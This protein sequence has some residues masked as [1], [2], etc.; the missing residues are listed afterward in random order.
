MFPWV[1]E[2]RAGLE[3]SICQ[4]IATEREWLPRHDISSPPPPPPHFYFDLG[5]RSTNE[6]SHRCIH[7]GDRYRVPSY[8]L[9]SDDS[10]GNPT[11]TCCKHRL[12]LQWVT[13]LHRCR[14]YHTKGLYRVCALSGIVLGGR[15]LQCLCLLHAVLKALI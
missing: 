14:F 13:T 8:I 7:I 6:R 15:F 1:C 3:R 4:I 10:Y 9:C 2:I 12:E 11:I 5:S